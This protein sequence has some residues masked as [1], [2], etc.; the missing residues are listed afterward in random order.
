MDARKDSKH[1][2]TARA[3]TARPNPRASH[4]GTP[5]DTATPRPSD[6]RTAPR[7]DFA[8][9]RAFVDTAASDAPVHIARPT[10]V[11]QT[12]SAPPGPPSPTTGPPRSTS[13]GPRPASSTGATAPR[14]GPI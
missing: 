5:T 2:G 8:S 13:S 1:A 10:A 9:T 4:I 12:N 11:S 14:N 6:P 3:A 7:T